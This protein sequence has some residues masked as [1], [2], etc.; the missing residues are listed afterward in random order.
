MKWKK[1]NNCN[2]EISNFGIVRSKRFG[3]VKPKMNK[4]G[5]HKVSI[6]TNNGRKIFSIHI[7]VLE[8]FG[9]PKPSPEHEANHIDGDKSF[10]WIGNLEW[11]T[12]KENI[13]HA[14]DNNLIPVGS[15]KYNSKLEEKDIPEIKKLSKNYTHQEIADLYGVSRSKITNILNEKAW[16]HTLKDI[17]P[18]E[19]RIPFKKVPTLVNKLPSYYLKWVAENWRE[20]SERN[21]AICRA[22]DQ[23][24][25]FRKEHGILDEDETN[26]TYDY[27]FFRKEY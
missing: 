13:Q 10:N 19:I 20:D 11:L 25:Q 2:Y 6:W 7:L 15:E 24:Y 26:N 17:Q 16:K 5:Y 18:K 12:H 27:D 1:I 22:A 3:R 23:E 9:P 4:K 14:K 8:Y 21:K